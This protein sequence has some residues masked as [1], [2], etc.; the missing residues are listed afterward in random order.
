M[1]RK[2][3]MNI[4]IYATDK[5]QLISTIDDFI[6]KFPKEANSTQGAI[7]YYSFI[8]LECGCTFTAKTKDDILGESIKCEHGNYFIKYDN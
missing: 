5:T 2:T 3:K 4:G 8:Q 1:E 6:E 7:T